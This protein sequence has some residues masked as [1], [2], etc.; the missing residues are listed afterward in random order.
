MISLFFEMFLDCS[1]TK[2][3]VSD[4]TRV[5]SYRESFLPYW[6]TAVRE[7]EK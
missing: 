5:P 1:W 3:F 4:P 2:R 7:S 6:I